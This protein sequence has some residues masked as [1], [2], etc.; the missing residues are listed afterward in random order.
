MLRSRLWLMPGEVTMQ[1]VGRRRRCRRGVVD[2]VIRGEAL[3]EL[4][5][6]GGLLQ[7]GDVDEAADRLR[8]LVDALLRHRRRQAERGLHDLE[9]GFIAEDVVGAGDAR[10]HALEIQRHLRAGAGLPDIRLERLFVEIADRRLLERGRTRRRGAIGGEIEG[11]GERLVAR[12]VQR[13]GETR[14]ARHAAFEHF[15]D[16]PFG[17]GH[18]ARG[19]RRS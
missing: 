2:V 10:R 4:L 8:L 19:R 16:K 13:I 7:I 18:V 15:A 3:D 9:Q 17:I 12:I 5:Q 11:R 1:R 14:A 6:I